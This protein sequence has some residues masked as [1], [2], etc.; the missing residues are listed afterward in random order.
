[1]GWNGRALRHELDKQEDPKPGHHEAIQPGL[2]AFHSGHLISV[3]AAIVG[4]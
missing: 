1:V 4:L 2:Q 3:R